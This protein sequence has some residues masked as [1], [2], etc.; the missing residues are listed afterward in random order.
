MADDPSISVECI[1]SGFIIIPW[2]E[3]KSLTNVNNLIQRIE[4]KLIDIEHPDFIRDTWFK[5]MCPSH[6]IRLFLEHG[7]PEIF[8]STNP[9]L[10]NIP[11]N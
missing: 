10:D 1:G 8:R 3:L 11:N 2:I 4:Q 9:I 6:T 5:I 7:G